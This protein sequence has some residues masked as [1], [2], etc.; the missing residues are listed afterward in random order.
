MFKQQIYWNIIGPFTQNLFCF[1]GINFAVG[2]LKYPDWLTSMFNSYST[3]QTPSTNPGTPPAPVGARVS[4]S[5]LEGESTW[6]PFISAAPWA[7]LDWL[8]HSAKVQLIWKAIAVYT[9]VK[10]SSFL[11]W[12]TFRKGGICY[13]SGENLTLT[14]S[15]SSFEESRQFSSWV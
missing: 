10:H 13:E 1:G 2:C 15:S 6:S 11:S 5:F 9:L 14:P 7:L 12:Q 3:T 8:Q 4:D